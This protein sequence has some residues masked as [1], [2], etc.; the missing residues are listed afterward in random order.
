[1]IRDFNLLATADNFNRSQ[2][3][4]ELWMLLR[5]VGDETP[6]VDRSPVKGLITARTSLDPLEAIGRLREELREKSKHFKVLL[7]VMPI[8]ARVTTTLEDIVEASRSL[9]SK[10]P[11]EETYRITVEKRRTDLRSME[12]ID[13]VAEGIERRVDLENPDWILLIQI[14]GR[15]TGISVIP[16]DGLLNVQKER[17]ALSA[18]GK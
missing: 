2:A 12:V 9:A 4:S 16:S 8:E 10:V 13:A 1:M 11:E 7:R 15:T 5:A 6:E 17:A 14:L 18:K 3:C